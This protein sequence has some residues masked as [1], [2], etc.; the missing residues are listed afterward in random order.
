M[1]KLTGELYVCEQDRET[2]VRQLVFPDPACIPMLISGPIGAVT[3]RRIAE[4]YFA[5]TAGPR[6][7]YIFTSNR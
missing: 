5:G 1:T 4:R 6:G 2:E 7:P 3:T